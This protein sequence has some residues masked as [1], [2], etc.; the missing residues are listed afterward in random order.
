MLKCAG[1][2]LLSTV[3]VYLAIDM[4]LWLQYTQYTVLST[5]IMY[6][7]HV[8]HAQYSLSWVTGTV[9]GCWTECVS[10]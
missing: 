2:V 5:I 10:M 7:C 6:Y 3:H 1:H 9:S 8:L 4:L